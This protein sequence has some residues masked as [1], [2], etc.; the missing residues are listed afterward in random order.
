MG[1]SGVERLCACLVLEVFSF[2]GLD[3]ILRLE[4]AQVVE[5]ETFVF[6]VELSGTRFSMRD[7]GFNVVVDKHARDF[8]RLIERDNG[9]R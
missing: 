7:D 2:P 6:T 5:V 4:V 8:V 9:T 3:H 1:V